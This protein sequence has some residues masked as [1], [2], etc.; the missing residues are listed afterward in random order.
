MTAIAAGRVLRQEVIGSRRLSNLFWAVVVTLGG[1]GFLLSGISS[2]TK[3]NLLPFANPTV[4]VFVPQGIVMGFYGVAAILL[5]TFLWL[6]M[7]WNVGGGYNEF[8]H[9]TGKITIFRQGYPGK[10]RKLAL[11]YDLDEAQSVKVDI[12]E[13]L[14]P[15]RA[16]Y[17]KIRKRG[18][19]PLTRVGQPV[20]L[21]ELENQGAALARFLQVPLE[22]L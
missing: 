12:K 6:L 15:K 2:Y 7:A 17:L 9:E 8:N 22:G 21:A 3:V 20:A 4:L 16:L 14:N 5:A 10:N 13:G 11:S 18:Q 19:I 1:I